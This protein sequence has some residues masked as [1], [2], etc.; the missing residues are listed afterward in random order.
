MKEGLTILGEIADGESYALILDPRSLPPLASVIARC[1][2]EVD[3]YVAESLLIRLSEAGEPAWADEL[4]FDA[5]ADAC[6]VRCAR[7][8]P[9]VHLLRR[10]RKNLAE[11]A[12]LRRLVKSLPDGL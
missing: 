10:L 9:L 7:K 4:T 2:R 11:P 5:E 3:G 12:R 8:A 1:G 6:T